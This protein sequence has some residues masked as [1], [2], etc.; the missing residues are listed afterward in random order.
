MDYDRTEIPSRYRRARVIPARTVERWR[1]AITRRVPEAEVARVLDL[2]CGTGRFCHLLADL[3]RARVFG[4]D[5]SQK[6]LAEARAEIDRPDITF[7]RGHAEA[8]PL[9]ASSCDLA[10]LSMIY[11]HLSD[12]AVAARECHRVLRPGG[13]LAIRQYTLD[14][15]DPQS[16]ERFFPAARAVAELPSV[17]DILACQAAAGFSL[18]SQDVV[19]HQMAE[20]YAGLL[21]KLAL[22][23]FSNLAAI[24]DAAFAAGLDAMRRVDSPSEQRALLS[25]SI[26][27]LVFRKA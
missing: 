1:A 8:I 7:H 21:E 25:L 13:Y 17:R 18:A 10:F 12:S 24:P 16:Y 26:D 2:G 27:L 15:Q 23:G 20:T 3:F 19:R 6:M 9:E 4:I 22:R 14:R 5:P 11:H